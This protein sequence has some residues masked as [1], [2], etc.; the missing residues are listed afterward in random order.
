MKL[1]GVLMIV[2]SVA[3]QGSGEKFKGRLAPVPA[4]GIPVPSVQGVGSASATLS[5]RKLTISG[6]FERMASPATIAKLCLGE[7][8]GVRGEPVFDLKVNRTGDGKTGTLEGTVDLTPQQVDALR[9][10]RFYIQIH[11]EGAPNGHL[12]GWLLK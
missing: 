1:L 9:K 11:S 3:A 4:L 7:L 5:G 6:T 10:G 2:M 12:M 8:T